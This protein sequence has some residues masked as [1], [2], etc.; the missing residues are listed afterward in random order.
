M[1]NLPTFENVCQK[2]FKDPESIKKCIIGG[3]LCFI[4]ILNVFAL[5]LMYR[6]ARQ[7]AK[8]HYLYIPQFK[9]WQKLFKEG[10]ILVALIAVFIIVPVSVCFLISRLFNLLFF[11]ML[12]MFS[13]FPVSAAL[14]ISP[15]LFASALYSFIQEGSWISVLDWRRILNRILP[16]WKAFI[17]PSLVFF[18][19]V[20]LGIPFYGLSLFIGFILIIGYTFTY[21]NSISESELDHLS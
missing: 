17:V 3:L 6:Y 9:G 2:V 4:P 15:V 5:G 18:G 13:L 12:G 16:H 7:V 8:T 21:F 20:S 1:N 14:F 11:Q 19:L 10:L